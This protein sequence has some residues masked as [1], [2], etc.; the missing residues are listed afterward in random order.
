MIPRNTIMLSDA[1]NDI[2]EYWDYEG[3][4]G[5][6]PSEFLYQSNLKVKLY[7]KKHDIHYERAVC[8][9]TSKIGNCRCKKCNEERKYRS[10]IEM[11][12]IKSLV[13][14]MPEIK[15]YWVKELNEFPLEM[16]PCRSDRIVTL[17]CKEHNFYF[18]KRITTIKPGLGICPICSNKIKPLQ[19]FYPELEKEYS[20]KNV[21]PFNCLNENSPVQVIWKCS[22]EGC[23]CE[24]VTDVRLR[25]A[26]R[27]RCPNERIHKKII[28]T[29][30]V[31]R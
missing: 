14:Y 4:K 13:E 12:K 8:G 21:I 28:A 9:I 18:K 16:M 24:W 29:C 30:R 17:Y 5:K 20:E 22:Y 15:D 23:D 7:C 10:A 19:I 31:E 26:G 11:G 27:T 6:D 3:N 2:Y 1:C 25:T